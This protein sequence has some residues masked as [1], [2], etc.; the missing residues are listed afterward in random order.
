M[1]VYVDHIETAGER[2]F[3]EPC[4]FGLE[5]LVAKRAD[6]RYRSGRHES[7]VKLKCTKSDSFPIVAFVEKL[8]AHPRRIASLYIGRRE[9]DR[10]L[11]AGKAVRPTWA[12]AN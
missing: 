9:G 5:G 1:L 6:S 11:Y 4:R 7:W 3:K 8:G 10:L 12:M 2:I